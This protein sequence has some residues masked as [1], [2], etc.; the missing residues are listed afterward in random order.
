MSDPVDASESELLLE[1]IARFLEREV[2]PAVPEPRLHFRLLIAAHLARTIAE[3]LRAGEATEAARI[4]RLRALLPDVPLPSD[5]ASRASRSAA[6]ATLERALADRLRDG[7]LEPAR[8]L[9]EVRR[10]LAERL[11]I[12]S[13]RFDLDTID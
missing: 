13:P 4:E 2:R 3:E 1:A 9:G 11:A 12:V 8:A 7:R 10:A 6:L 5:I